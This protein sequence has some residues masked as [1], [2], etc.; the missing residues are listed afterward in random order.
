MVSQLSCPIHF[1]LIA[2]LS[3]AWETHTLTEG[4]LDVWMDE[5]VSVVMAPVMV[6][7]GI[8]TVMR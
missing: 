3:L 6:D 2:Y 4:K 7:M 8:N 1:N 5:R